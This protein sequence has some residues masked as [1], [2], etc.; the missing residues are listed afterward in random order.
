MFA[1]TFTTAEDYVAFGMDFE[2]MEAVRAEA[3][4]P[5]GEPTEADWMEFVE[6]TKEADAKLAM[7]IKTIRKG[8]RNQPFFVIINMRVAKPSSRQ[9]KPIVKYFTKGTCACENIHKRS[10][11]AMRTYPAMRVAKYRRL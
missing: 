11:L 10:L 3:A 9:L 6:W 7:Q 5:E 1:N 8:L 2:E 4:R